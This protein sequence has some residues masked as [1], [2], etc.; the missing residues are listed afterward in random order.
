M[1][2]E[3]FFHDGH[4]GQIIVPVLCPGNSHPNKWYVAILKRV[5][6]KIRKTYPQLAITIG[7]DRGFSCSDFY[8]LADNYNLKYA[9]GLASNPVLKAK[10][11]Q[12]SS[13]RTYLLEARASLFEPLGT[14]LEMI[15]P[16]LILLFGARRRND[17]NCICHNNSAVPKDIHFSNDLNSA[18]AISCFDFLTL[19]S[20]NKERA[21]PSR[22]LPNI[23]V[24]IAIPDF[25]VISEITLSNRRFISLKA[26]F[27][28]L[29]IFAAS[30][31]KELRCLY[32]MRKHS[33]CSN[34][35]K[36]P[37]SKPKECNFCIH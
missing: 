11:W 13:I 37:L 36:E 35:K 3:L 5:L 7:A 33:V 25:L 2:N 8:V 27:I 12:I 14:R 1:Y 22:S 6:I 4:T 17:V 19:L 28:L 18:L 23:A 9:I 26:L 15:L 20:D 34:G 30:S 10:T 24:I 21:F 32:N 16:L 31:T 29:L